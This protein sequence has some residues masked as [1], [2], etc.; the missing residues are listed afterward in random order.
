MAVDDIELGLF[1]VLL[2]TPAKEVREVPVDT[3]NE[4]FE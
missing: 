2:R 3:Q 1:F 4:L